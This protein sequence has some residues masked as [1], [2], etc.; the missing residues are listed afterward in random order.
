MRKTLII[1]LLL[2]LVSTTMMAQT[3]KTK[4]EK[5]DFYLIPRAGITINNFTDVKGK[6]RPGIVIGGMVEAFI[7]PRLA[8]D[9]DIHFTTQGCNDCK[10]KHTITYAQSGETTVERG[11]RN[12]RLRYLNTAY[13]IRY[14]LNDD[15]SVYTGLNMGRLVFARYT[16]RHGGQT[17]SCKNYFHNGDVAFPVGVTYDIN[18][19][20]FD[21]RYNITTRRITNATIS[22]ALLHNSRN[23]TFMFTLGYKCRMF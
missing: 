6:I 16:E 1:T 23:S 21:A 13:L 14:Y 8:V 7:T 15:L 22:K 19:W 5:L 10:W 17:H 3:P 4:Y 2:T 11:S 9:M 20:S 12:Y 18:K